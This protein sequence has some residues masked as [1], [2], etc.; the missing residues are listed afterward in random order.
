MWQRV[1]WL[2]MEVLKGWLVISFAATSLLILAL[3]IPKV[4]IGACAIVFLVGALAVARPNEKIAEWSDALWLP[5]FT[6][7]VLIAL[8][9]LVVM[10]SGGQVAERSRQYEAAMAAAEKARKAELRK[11]NPAQYLAELQAK[12]DPSW[13]REFEALDPS[14]YEQYSAEQQRKLEA[15]RQADIKLLSEQL[16]RTSDE[17][18]AQL[19]IYERLAGLDRSNKEYAKQVSLLKPKVDALREARELA[20]DQLRNPRKYVTLSNFRWSK[21]GFGTVMLASFTIKN[22]LPFDVRDIGVLCTLSGSSGSMIDAKGTVLYLKV[23]AKSSKRSGEINL[24]FVNQQAASA[25]CEV[26][27]VEPD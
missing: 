2:L 3:T 23:P 9:I 18:E 10:F 17:I 1:K 24:G 14:G 11:S 20:A 8:S 6:A 16:S 25:N 4:A 22:E 5:Q 27:K 12:N 19:N 21:G 26:L 7:G 13:E 15:Q